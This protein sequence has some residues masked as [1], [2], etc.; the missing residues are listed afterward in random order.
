M[1]NR[2]MFQRNGRAGYVLKPLALRTH[3]KELL[4]RHTQHSLEIVVCNFL[5]VLDA[6]NSYA[7]IG[8]LCSTAASSERLPR[9]RDLG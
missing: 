6:S 2:A 4:F 3:D 8:H 9:T 5:A 7:F 1:I